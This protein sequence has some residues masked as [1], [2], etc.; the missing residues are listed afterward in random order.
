MSIP[1]IPRERHTSD[2]QTEPVARP[3]VW[4]RI[5]GV[6]FGETKGGLVA[7]YRFAVLHS[8]EGWSDPLIEVDSRGRRV[9]EAFSA[10]QLREQ[11]TGEPSERDAFRS[12]V[13]T[14]GPVFALGV[15]MDLLPGRVDL[16]MRVPGDPMWQI[17][18]EVENLRGVIED[19][20]DLA[21]GDL[22]A[23]ASRRSEPGHRDE[24]DV[25]QTDPVDVYVRRMTAEWIS[26]RLS[27]I[28]LRVAADPSG[29]FGLTL[30]MQ[31]LLDAIYWQ[32]LEHVRRRPAREADSLDPR[33]RIPWCGYCGGAILSTRLAEDRVN[34]WHAG[35]KAAGQ[36]QRRREA[37][38]RR[39]AS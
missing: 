31:S 27:S 9:L 12:F 5:S 6:D 21:R 11:L 1:F 3:G 39:S 19:V 10:L 33:F 36:A 4:P 18:F 32:L 37:A 29:R 16:G 23:L 25:W 20:D 34:K 22:H 15:D 26:T 38:K 30:R 24:H 13:L 2:W 14:F 28:R 35:C 7:R 17:G 8:H